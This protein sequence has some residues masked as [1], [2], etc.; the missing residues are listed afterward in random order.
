MITILTNNMID[1]RYYCNLIPVDT[2]EKIKSDQNFADDRF[3]SQ[4]HWLQKEGVKINY[5]TELELRP[6]IKNVVFPVELYWANIVPNSNYHANLKLLKEKDA[7]ILFWWPKE[8]WTTNQYIAKAI[9]L[10]GQ[11]RIT[12]V[13]GNLKKSSIDNNYPNITYK[14]FDFWWFFLKHYYNRP[15]LDIDKIETYEFTFFNRRLNVPR[16]VIYYKM[17]TSGKLENSKH[18]FH[19]SYG[20]GNPHSKDEIVKYLMQEI[21]DFKSLNYEICE[22][23]QEIT[24]D[25]TWIDWA[26]TRFQEHIGSHFPPLCKYYLSDD[27]NNISYLDLI[28][29]T[30]VYPNSDFLFITEKTYRSIANGNIF[31]IMGCPGTIKYLQEKGIQTFNDLFDESYDDPNITHWYDRWKIIEKNIDIWRALGGEGRRNYYIKSFDKLVHNQNIL[32]SRSLK[33]EIVDLFRK[34]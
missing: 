32:Y 29:E 25:P 5:M 1:N 11:H 20:V 15:A 31:L 34:I 18:S 33:E 16:C 2:W 27:L 23:Y 21:N 10:F 26:F 8:S 4:M 14:G 9:K 6:E 17:L 3:F 24:N 19:A 13:T 28:T 30:S 22:E 12:F 7:T